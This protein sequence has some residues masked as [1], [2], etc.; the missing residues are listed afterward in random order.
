MDVLDRVTA[1]DVI[2]VDGDVPV[3]LEV[4]GAGSAEHSVDVY[5][6][7]V[8]GEFTMREL[9]RMR[10][11]HA[12]GTATLDGVAIEFADAFVARFT[13]HTQWRSRG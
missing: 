3:G 12:G 1:W 4:A 10:G 9:S 5:R 13:S 6:E 11:Y 7:S 2:A 8:P